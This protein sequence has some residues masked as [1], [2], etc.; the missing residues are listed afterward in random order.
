MTCTRLAVRGIVALFVGA[1]LMTGARAQDRRDYDRHDPY[2]GEHWRFDD[3]HHHGHYYPSLGYVVAALPPGVLTLSFHN[4]RLFFDAGVWYEPV[5]GGFVVARPPIGI[6]V[7]SLPP[8]YSTVWVGRVP[9]YYANN[10][11]Y[12]ARQN[13]YVVVDQPTTYVEAPPAAPAPSSPQVAPPS[14]AAQGP[15]GSWYYCD[16][17][18][19]YYP[20][21]ANCPEGWRTVPAT[22]PGR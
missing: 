16:S 17:A 8:D 13:G 21:A 14:Q 2:R 15:A 22:P 12:A 1:C 20:Y 9:Y 3:R 4:R 7:P 11:Y 18:K 6:F 5:G 10:V 19:A